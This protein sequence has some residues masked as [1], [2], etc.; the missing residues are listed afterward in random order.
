MSRSPDSVKTCFSPSPLPQC[1]K[2][3]PLLSHGRRGTDPLVS[4]AE[5]WNRTKRAHRRAPWEK[6]LGSSHCHGGTV[7]LC[8]L[9]SA[10]CAVCCVLCAV[11]SPRCFALWLQAEPRGAWD[12]RRISAGRWTTT[13]V[14]RAGRTVP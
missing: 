5:K 1:C 4:H 8:A 11:C 7:V 12:E 13:R 6:L 10:P 14:C 2:T 3:P 9:C